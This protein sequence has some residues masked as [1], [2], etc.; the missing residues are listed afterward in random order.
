MSLMFDVHFF[1]L[2]TNEGQ[3]LCGPLKT[4][5]ILK[6]MFGIYS[7]INSD[8]YHFICNYIKYNMNM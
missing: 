4:I 1:V 5:A 2:A 7:L 6:N 8:L 3:I